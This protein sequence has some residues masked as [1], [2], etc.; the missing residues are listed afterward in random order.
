MSNAELVRERVARIT[1]RLKRSFD[2][3]DEPFFVA[4]YCNSCGAEAVAPDV[5]RLI[6]QVED[7]SLDEDV[8]R[9]IDLCPY[10]D[11]TNTL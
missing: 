9:A 5:E 8:A 7:W 3:E 6:P 10:C 4:V 1:A 11:R 2:T